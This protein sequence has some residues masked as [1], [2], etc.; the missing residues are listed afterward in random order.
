MYLL[1]G[2]LPFFLKGLVHM[3]FTYHILQLHIFCI[4]LNLLYRHLV[5]SAMPDPDL[6]SALKEFTATTEATQI[7]TM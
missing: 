2:S 3:I 1:T 6:Y 5:Q 4:M 7:M